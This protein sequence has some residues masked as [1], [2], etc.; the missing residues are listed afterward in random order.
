VVSMMDGIL[1]GWNATECAECLVLE[2]LRQR[3]PVPDGAVRGLSVGLMGRRATMIK[4]CDDGG[5]A[6]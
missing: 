2:F 4:N 6:D 1:D 3:G 5:V